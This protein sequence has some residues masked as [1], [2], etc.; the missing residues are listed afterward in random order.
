MKKFFKFLFRL[1][2]IAGAAVGAYFAYKKFAGCE[3]AEEDEI[4]DDLD[5]FELDDEDEASDSENVKAPEYVSI[6]TPEE[7]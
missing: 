2:A 1:I 6:N 4:E 5:E 3:T 7:E